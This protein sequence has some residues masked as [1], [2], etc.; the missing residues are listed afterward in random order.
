MSPMRSKGKVPIDIHT[1]R[2]LDA[3][4]ESAESSEDGFSRKES[5]CNRDR[6]TST[7]G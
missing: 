5:S 3:S 7:E 6:C 2:C 1:L 4:V